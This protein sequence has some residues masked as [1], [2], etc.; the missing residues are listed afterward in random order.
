M[1]ADTERAK[2]LVSQLASG[3]AAERRH[4][5]LRLA[6][7]PHKR[8]VV[9][10]QD[11][12][13]DPDEGVRARAAYSLGR[14]RR[15]ESATGL[16]ERLVDEGESEE[17]RTQS[18]RALALI[19]GTAAVSALIG[20]L[21]DSSASVRG[22]ASYALGEVRARQASASLASLLADPDWEVRWQAALALFKLDEPS[23]VAALQQFMLDRKTPADLRREIPKMIQALQRE[24]PIGDP[25]T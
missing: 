9:A 12:L 24:P 19:G 20:V 17:V 3:S 15:R 4:A 16:C 6:K 10:L 21:H 5:A 7:F 13:K 23:V 11:A 8:A 1:C 14:L 18:A 2:E 25:T 22:M